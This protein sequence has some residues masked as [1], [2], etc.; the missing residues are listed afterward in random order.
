MARTT[1]SE[2]VRKVVIKDWIAAQFHHS[3]PWWD[4]YELGFE[5]LKVA[6]VAQYKDLDFSFLEE[7]I[8]AL[9]PEV[10]ESTRPELPPVSEPTKVSTTPLPNQVAP[11]SPS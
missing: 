8:L 3:D 11:T 10:Q 2:E 7:S 6:V 9:A 4:V 1:V 5:N